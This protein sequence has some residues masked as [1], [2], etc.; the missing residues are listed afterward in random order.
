MF[1]ENAVASAQA[2]QSDRVVL[3]IGDSI[4][5]GYCNTVRDHLSGIVDVLYPDENCRH[6]HHV[7]TMLD[8]WAH[9]CPK[10]QV[11]VVLFNCGHWDCAHWGDD[12][13]PLT[14]LPYYAENIG[15]I[16]DRLQ[17]IYPCAKIVFA[18]TTPMNPN[19]VPGSNPRT[20]GDIMRYN[21]AAEQ[22]LRARNGAILDLFSYTKD[23]DETHY[24]DYCHFTPKAFETLGL[25]VAR[26]IEALIEQDHSI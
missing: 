11:K 12:R 26:Q 3:L 18:T 24:M 25:F 6:T 19:G 15:R 4:R 20:T 22:M 1:A 10:E 2:L 23:W 7:L 16:F 13:A 17:E 9:L 14:S 8:H 5:I 21:A